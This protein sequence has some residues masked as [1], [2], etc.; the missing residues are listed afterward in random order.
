ME[1]ELIEVRVRWANGDGTTVSLSKFDTVGEL[2]A[3]AGVPA[4]SGSRVIAAHRGRF[5]Q[6]AMSLGFYGITSGSNVICA[7]RRDSETKPPRPPCSLARDRFPNLELSR[8]SKNVWDELARLSDLSFASWEALP[9]YGS[10]M[11]ELMKEQEE[12]SEGRWDVHFTVVK[13]EKRI[14]E[15]P[16]PALFPDCAAFGTFKGFG[17]DV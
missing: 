13:T 2:I 10:I 5:L 17:W 3:R 15:E 1:D 8:E 6:D 11:K 16:L 4:P 14:C 7:L 9:E 12:Q